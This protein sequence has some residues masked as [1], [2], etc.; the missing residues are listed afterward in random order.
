MYHQKYAYAFISA[1]EYI[2][3]LNM[4]DYIVV[5]QITAYLPYPIAPI[6]AYLPDHVD[7]DHACGHCSARISTMFN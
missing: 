1:R 6:A 5:S 7:V 4:L 2:R 3:V